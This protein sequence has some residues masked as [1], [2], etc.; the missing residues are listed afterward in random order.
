M[1]PADGA[2]HHPS[3]LAKATA[4]GMPSLGHQGSKATSRELD[5]V[6]RGIVGSIALD[7]PEAPARR[8]W[9]SADGRNGVH[10][11]D[12]LGHVMAIG[13]REGHG[14]WSAFRVNKDMVFR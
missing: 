6:S 2:L 10:Q 14:H 9:L 3:M 8:P 7:D 5:S 1:K 4:V 11:R 12:E 13:R